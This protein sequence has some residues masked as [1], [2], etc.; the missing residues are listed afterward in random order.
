MTKVAEEKKPTRRACLLCRSG[1]YAHDPDAVPVCYQCRVMRKDEL[2]FWCPLCQERLRWRRDWKIFLGKLVC[3]QCGN[4]AW[5][6][7]RLAE[8]EHNARAQ[9]LYDIA[10]LI[11]WPLY[12]KDKMIPFAVYSATVRWGDRWVGPPCS[13]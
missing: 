9:H 13:Q 4:A 12:S 8:E 3:G 11:V 7:K 6:L 2:S 10:K 5:S 1:F